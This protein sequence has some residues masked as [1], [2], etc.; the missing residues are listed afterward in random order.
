MYGFQTFGTS[1][2]S[3][4]TGVATVKI[5]PNEKNFYLQFMRMFIFN[6]LQIDNSI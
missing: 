3:V 6:K 4:K 2:V 5:L 1:S